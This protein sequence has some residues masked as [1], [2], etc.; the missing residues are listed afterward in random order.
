[1]IDKLR[2]IL[3]D[4]GSIS[5]QVFQTSRDIYSKNENFRG[6]LE[7]VSIS[8]HEL[9]AGAGQIS[10]EVSGVSITSKDIEVK[11]VTYAGSTKEMKDRSD[12]MM[13]LV[14]KGRISVESQG[15]G[16]KRNVEVT[17]Q[18]SETIDMLARQA[19]GISNVTR[20]ISEIAEQTN[21]L[22]LN[23]SIEAARAG[24]HGRGFAVVASEVRKLAEEST[25]LTREVFGF[26]KSIE[27]GIQDAIRSIQ[28]NEDVVKKQTV[29]IDQTET[30][31]AQIVDSVGF[32][33]EEITR[34]AEESEQMLISSGQIAA[35]MEN[36]SAITEESAAGTQEVSAS[37]NEQIA[38]V[39][40][41]VSQAEEMTRVVTQLQQTIQ[42]FKL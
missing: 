26:V 17:G 1:M 27:Q 25:S 35:A 37:M 42:V 21:L 34:F 20:A 18:V 14:E 30:V 10:E 7:Q 33:S 12:H 29:L 28:V 15:I 32:I 19:A 4:T 24:E 11:L 6:V 13:S 2:D 40:G 3:R 5:K 38:T 36:I 16:M 39:Q 23:A 31:F 41:I 9:A 8:A 22:S